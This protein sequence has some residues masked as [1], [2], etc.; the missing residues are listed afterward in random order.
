MEQIPPKR[1]PVISL[2]ITKF[3]CNGYRRQ[4]TPQQQHKKALIVPIPYSS[5]HKARQPGLTLLV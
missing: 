3:P 4:G 1:L 2:Y 5:D